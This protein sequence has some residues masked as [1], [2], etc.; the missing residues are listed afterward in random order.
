MKRR[1]LLAAGAALGA[2]WGRSAPAVAAKPLSS[3]ELEL[4]I[5]KVGADAAFG[6][7]LLAVPK[8][9]PKDPE[10]LVLLHGLGETHDSLVGARAFAE[11]YGLLSAVS[12]LMHPPVARTLKA[13]DYFGDGR[14]DAIN[15]RLSARPFKCPVLLCPFTPN[16]YKTGGDAT[17]ARFASFLVGSLKADV[18]QRT[19]LTF[20][21][22]RCMVSGVSLGGYLAIEVFLRSAEHFAGLGTAQGAFGPNQ[23][24]RYAQGVAAAVSRVG[25]RRVEI[26][27]STSDSY[28]RVNELFHQHLQKQGQTSTLRVSPGPHDQ[29]WLNESGTIEMLLS[30]DEV[31]AARGSAP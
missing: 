25:A 31:F 22:K 18:E 4:S 17:I 12:R 5:F 29:R 15:R 16:P 11:R 8:A 27:T 19:G 23:A 30:A 21:A 1:A 6:R 28:R 2:A 10:L 20:P 14:L 7:A 26:L 13:Q 24:A 3:D 9:L